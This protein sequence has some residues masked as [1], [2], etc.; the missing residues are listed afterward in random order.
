M[1]HFCI[2]YH[3]M[4]ASIYDYV[5]YTPKE[6]ISESPANYDSLLQ[7]FAGETKGEM[8]FRNKVPL[9]GLL[10]FLL[11]VYLRCNFFIWTLLLG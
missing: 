9:W 2:T 7:C 6:V 10:T 4:A 11:C 5:K 8:T 1:E 3:H